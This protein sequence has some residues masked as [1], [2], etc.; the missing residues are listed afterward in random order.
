[1][2]KLTIVTINYHSDADIK[3]LK[4][5][6]DEQITNFK[7]IFKVRDNNT[8]NIG[9]GRAIN[10]IGLTCPTPY[11]LI[12]NPDTQFIH[13][14]T[15]QSMVDMLESNERIGAL[16]PKLID[17][18]NRIQ[19]SFDKRPSLYRMITDKPL[20]LL[21]KYFGNNDIVSKILKLL[22]IKYDLKNSHM[23][24]DWVSGAALLVRTDVFNKVGGFDPNI[25]MYFED[26][27]LCVRIKS[28]G[29]LIFYDSTNEIRHFVG[30]SFQPNQDKSKMYYDSQDYYFKKHT[31]RLSYFIIK[32]IRVHYQKLNIKLYINRY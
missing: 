31:N 9:Y 26:V 22:A 14:D 8:D 21:Y 3:R 20:A 15:L 27:D 10:E 7:W 12:I 11:V 24:I 29:Y 2:E 13:P 19:W 16:G 4:L 23:N 25:F 6:L 1:M 32:S 17:K 5:S 30:Q 18:D 28:M